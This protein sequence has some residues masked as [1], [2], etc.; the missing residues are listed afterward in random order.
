MHTNKV[1]QIDIREILR[2][3]APRWYKKIPG[4]FISGLEK[5]ICLDKINE[6]IRNNADVTGVDFM[7][8]MIRDFGINLQ[9]KGENNL[10]E[11]NR[12]CIFVSNHPLGGLDGICLSAV[13]G[14]KY[15][16]HI[17][18]IVNDILYFIV[19]LQEIFVPINKHGN[20][21]KEAIA[22][23]NEA[24]VS[25]N[26]IITF[27]A[28]LCSRET[29]GVIK[30]LPWK[31]MF[32]SKAIEYQRDVVPVYFEAT[33]S[34]LFYKIANIRKRLGFKFNLEMLLLPREMFKAQG[35][36][37][38]IHFGK[39]IPWS[40]FNTFKSPQQWANMVEEIVYK[41]R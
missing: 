14:K 7:E 29:D 38:V 12:K 13:L 25:D 30:D 35:A 11:F 8:N 34:R 27:P 19:P 15:H 26:Q 23:L 6:L 3:K 36:T 21:A 40:T 32:I 22:A 37:F 5:L 1:F 41:T 10:P 24:F 16:K 33:N 20:Q 31:K 9:L 28:G 17:Q 18:Y 4:F 2:S 39:P